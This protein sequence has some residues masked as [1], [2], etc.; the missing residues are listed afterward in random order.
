M[1]QPSRPLPSHCCSGQILDA[2]DLFL[3]VH[4]I[5]KDGRDTLSLQRGNV[6]ATNALIK[7]VPLDVEHSLVVS[8]LFVLD[9]VA[10]LVIE[11]PDARVLVVNVVTGLYAG[12]L[13]LLEF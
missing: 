8:V 3:H 9:G 12:K 6:Q 10:Q 2:N 7:V 11:G 5:H 1:L 13:R 4:A